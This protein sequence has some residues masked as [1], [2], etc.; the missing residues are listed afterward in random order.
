[1]PGPP[2]DPSTEPTELELEQDELEISDLQP[3]RVGNTGT[4][5]ML[6]SLPSLRP[7]QRLAL[8][9][10]LVLLLA[11]V[12]VGVASGRADLWRLVAAQAA[13]TPTA[14]PRG[15]VVIISTVISSGLL[16]LPT[17]L[18][19]VSGVPAVG[20]APAT[21]GKSPPP[22]TEDGPPTVGKAIGK[23]PVLVGG[24]T[25]SYATLRLDTGARAALGWTAPYTIYGWP[26]P[27]ALIAHNGMQPGLITLTGTDPRTQ[28]PL[29]FGLVPSGSHTVP[30]VIAPKLTLDPANP[31][32]SPGGWSDGETFWYGYIFLP[33]EG[34]YTL[35]ATWP[36]GGWSFDV[37]A[38]K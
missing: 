3:P 21:C 38:G 2:S 24:F 37:S 27:I 36:G 14:T 31:S 22:L 34:C 10:S 16:L 32:V 1:M 19:G 15:N 35:T 30:A 13:P 17:P 7:R 6:V 33:R 18:P 23:A 26:A 28:Y 5:Q 25:G 8:S 9:V 20:P 12:L 4:K 29:W 11:I